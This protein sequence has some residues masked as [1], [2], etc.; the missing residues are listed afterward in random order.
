MQQQ[1][2]KHDHIKCCRPPYIPTM[3]MFDQIQIPEIYIFDDYVQQHPER[4]P[5]ALL[6]NCF[7]REPA[8]VN[9][10]LSA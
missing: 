1:H 4:D 2:G 3:K 7:F 10:P 8:K 5:T 6:P 9:N